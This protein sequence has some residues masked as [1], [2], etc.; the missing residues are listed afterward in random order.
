MPLRVQLIDGSEHLRHAVELLLAMHDDIT[1]VRGEPDIVLVDLRRP[2]G[3]SF[4]ALRRHAATEPVVALA[5]DGIQARAALAHG[6]SEAV[7]KADGARAFLA[8]LRRVAGAGAPAVA[9]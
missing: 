4:R 7:V 6:A 1:L 3:R 8:A 9:A 5:G 2:L